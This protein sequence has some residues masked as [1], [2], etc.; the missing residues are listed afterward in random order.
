MPARFKLSNNDLEEIKE[1]VKLAEKTISGEIVPVIIEQSDFYT[2]SYYKVLSFGSFGTLF[3]IILL[4][5]F[6]PDYAIFDPIY[7]L[8]SCFI[9]SSIL[10]SLI[11][12]IKPLKRLTIDDKI[13]D[14]RCWQKANEAFLEYEVFNTKERTGILIFISYFERRII[15]KAD[16]GIA[17][18]VDQQIWQKIA[19]EAAKKIKIGK[20]KEAIIET[21]NKCGDLLLQKG[22]V[23][24]SDDKNELSDELQIKNL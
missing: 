19:D 21:I 6:F 14:H 17:K 5:Y 18:V 1:H 8:L 7:I 15:I 20:T 2:E 13:L 3:G 24:R 4:N 10:A 23:I 9:I 16:S 12:F 11:F 22:F